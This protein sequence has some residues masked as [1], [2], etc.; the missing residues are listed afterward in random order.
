MEIEIQD[1][2]TEN[3]G[4]ENHENVSIETMT[5]FRN[6]DNK[7]NTEK[8]NIG[9]I[10]NQDK[11]VT[12]EDENEKPATVVVHVHDKNE[13]EKMP[14]KSTLKNKQTISE[15][16]NKCC[17]ECGEWCREAEMYCNRE[18]CGCY[19]SILWGNCCLTRC[20]R[21]TYYKLEEIKCKEVFRCLLSGIYILYYIGCL[22]IFICQINYLGHNS[23]SDLIYYE[24]TKKKYCFDFTLLTIFSF[25]VNLVTGFSLAGCIDRMFCPKKCWTQGWSPKKTLGPDVLMIL[26]GT[27]MSILYTWNYS[28]MSEN[29]KDIYGENL[30]KYSSVIVAEYINS[31]VR[32]GIYFMDIYFTCIVF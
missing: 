11:K 21:D 23:D 17:S 15:K 1:F 31:F 30:D 29:C 7:N 14:N 4:E 12:V 19:E 25:L 16:A 2:K 18:V 28:A 26:L 22:V 27:L 3:S 5:S 6:N 20:C 8:E 10:E 24:G 32:L 13:T 9:D